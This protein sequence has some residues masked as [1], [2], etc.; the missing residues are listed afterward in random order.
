VLLRAIDNGI[1]LTDLN[2]C[3]K[4]CGDYKTEVIRYACEQSMKYFQ[5]YY[6]RY[7]DWL[8]IDKILVNNPRVMLALNE[9]SREQVMMVVKKHPDVYEKIPKSI[10]L[11]DIDIA[12]MCDWNESKMDDEH[13]TIRYIMCIE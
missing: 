1:N 8:D 13:P 6:N 12:L 9:I 10:R 5:H 4:K 7:G 2:E 11:H 3:L